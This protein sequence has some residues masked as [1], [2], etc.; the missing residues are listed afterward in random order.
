MEI[1]VKGFNYRDFE[2][3]VNCETCSAKLKIYFDD[4][5][6]ED[7]LRSV[8][9]RCACCFTTNTIDVNNCVFEAV[10]Y[11][12]EESIKEKQYNE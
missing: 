9:F 11:R 7:Y 12:N 8:C 5:F 1:L 6:Y 2:E 3:I 10:D 4:L